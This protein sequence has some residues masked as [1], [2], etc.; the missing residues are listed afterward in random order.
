MRPVVLKHH[1]FTPTEDLVYATEIKEETGIFG[2]VS[3]VA[4]R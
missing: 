4:G 1:Y 3:V 2:N